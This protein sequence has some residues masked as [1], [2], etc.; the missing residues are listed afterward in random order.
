M[1]VALF[2]V[3]FN[4]LNKPPAPSERAA[5]MFSGLP[6]LTWFERDEMGEQFR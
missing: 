2:S 6:N 5:E 1:Y 4:V 3:F